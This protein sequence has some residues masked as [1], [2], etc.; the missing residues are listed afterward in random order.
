MES[1][2][3]GKGDKTY[4]PVVTGLAAFEVVGLFLSQYSAIPNQRPAPVGMN[5]FFH[6]LWMNPRTLLSKSRCA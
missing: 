6:S 5:M 2:L 1:H 3:S 4:Q